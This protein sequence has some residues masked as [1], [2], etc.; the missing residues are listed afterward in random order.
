MTWCTWLG[1]GLAVGLFLGAN[2]GFLLAGLCVM[3]S[4]RG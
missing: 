4:R 2:V 3:A 1:L